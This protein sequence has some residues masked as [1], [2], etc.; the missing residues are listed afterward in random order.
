M[1]IPRQ[2]EIILRRLYLI[3]YFKYLIIIRLYLIDRGEYSIVL[4]IERLLLVRN[5][6]LLKAF[7]NSRFQSVY[8]YISLYYLSLSIHDLRRVFIYIL[9][10]DTFEKLH[11]KEDIL[12]TTKS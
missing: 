4:K 6:L 10:R 9:F 1:R 5:N 7:V 12:S 11:K 8:L 3:K 2:V